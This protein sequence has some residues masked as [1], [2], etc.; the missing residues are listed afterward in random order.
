[1]PY[2]VIGFIQ[3]FCA[4]P[5]EFT[6]E[7]QWMQWIPPTI[8]LLYYPNAH[9]HDV[10]RG[11]WQQWT[12]QRRSSDPSLIVLTLF[13]IGP[14]TYHVLSKYSLLEKYKWRRGTS[15]QEDHDQGCTCTNDSSKC[16]IHSESS[17]S[18]DTDIQ[19]GLSSDEVST[20]QKMHGLHEIQTGRN[21]A[22]WILKFNSNSSQIYILAGAILAVALNQWRHIGPIFLLWLLMVYT[23]AYQQRNADDVVASICPNQLEPTVA[24][25]DGKLQEIPNKDLVPGDIIHVSEGCMIP[26]DGIVVVCS[27]ILQT[28]QSSITGDNKS[29]SKHEDD[30]CYWGTG[31]LRGDA[32]LQIK[33][34]GKKTF[35]GRTVDLV[36]GASGQSET[37]EHIST[38]RIF[39]ARTDDWDDLACL[40]RTS[41]LVLAGFYLGHQIMA[42]DSKS[43]R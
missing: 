30:M 13:I 43:D 22:I 34:T 20:R 17:E 25:R 11:L 37:K 7:H 10:T 28:D 5:K 26:A 12:Q 2:A 31:V 16:S 32:L 29:I 8:L 42:R 21:W 41:C 40:G 9:L 1:M 6:E 4:N 36:Q 14:I 3:R 18:P 23:P 35:I 39:G 15:A 33:D 24:L 19:T 38:E 27:D